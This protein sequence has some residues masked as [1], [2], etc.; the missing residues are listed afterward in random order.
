MRLV[1]DEPV[2]VKSGPFYIDILL[3]ACDLDRIRSGEMISAFETVKGKRFYIGAL[4]E[5]RF[6]YEKEDIWQEDQDKES[7]E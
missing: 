3:S 1:I 2:D 7:Y 4:R 6:F 5:G